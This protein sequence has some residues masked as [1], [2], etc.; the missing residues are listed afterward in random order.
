MHR[1][2][3]VVNTYSACHDTLGIPQI[4]SFYKLEQYP[5]CT[6]TVEHGAPVEATAWLPGGSLLA[7]AGG[8][9]IRCNAFLHCIPA[10]FLHQQPEV[11]QVSRMCSCRPVSIASWIHI[12]Q[13]SAIH[14]TRRVY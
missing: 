2:R 10:I 13:A 12:A 9:E 6:M 4:F 8:T 3:P 1:T 14:P 7:T 5:Q 11:W